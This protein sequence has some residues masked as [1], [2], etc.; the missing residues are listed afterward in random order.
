MGAAS[1]R[2]GGSCL[3]LR[4]PT[5]DAADSLAPMGAC[6][7]AL[8]S[9]A[10]PNVDDVHWLAVRA[11]RAR[12]AGYTRSA[13]AAVEAVRAAL[14][15]LEAAGAPGV[16][17]IDQPGDVIMSDCLPIWRL[18][19]HD[20]KELLQG[21]ERAEKAAQ[22]LRRVVALA[23]HS[24]RRS[25]EAGHAAATRS[26]PSAPDSEVLDSIVEWSKKVDCDSTVVRIGKRQFDLTTHS[27]D[28]RF[29]LPATGAALHGWTLAGRVVFVAEASV[30]LCT[31]APSGGLSCVDPEAGSESSSGPARRLFATRDDH[32]DV[33]RA[34]LARARR[35]ALDSF[36]TLDRTRGNQSRVLVAVDF[37][38]KQWE[39]TDAEVFDP[40]ER[41]TRETEAKF[42]LM[43]YGAWQG[44]NE[45]KRHVYRIVNTTHAEV[46]AQASA[47]LLRE[48]A[49][50]AMVNDPDPAW[51]VDI[52]AFSFRTVTFPDVSSFSW[53]G[54]AQV[55]GAFVWVPGTYRGSARVTIHEN[56]HNLGLSHAGFLDNGYGNNNDNM[57]CCKSGHWF[58]Q[59]KMAINW[60]PRGL[61]AE[62][63]PAGPTPACPHCTRGGSFILFPHDLGVLPPSFQ[64]YAE[65]GALPSPPA[66][67]EAGANFSEISGPGTVITAIAVASNPAS[68]AGKNEVHQIWLDAKAEE[69]E[70]GAGQLLMAVGRLNGNNAQQSGYQPT[71]S[72]TDWSQSSLFRG[73]SAVAYGERLSD[74]GGSQPLSADRLL[75]A[76]ATG[77]RPAMLV[78]SLAEHDAPAAGLL[79]PG[80]A[81]SS[82]NGTVALE[83]EPQPR[84]VPSNFDVIP[85]GIRPA[86]VEDRCWVGLNA[87]S[88]AGAPTLDDPACS[89][90]A[91]PTRVSFLGPRGERATLGAG[92][93]LG[94]STCDRPATSPHGT[95]HMPPLQSSGGA[96]APPSAAIAALAASSD[97]MS[98]VGTVTA[99]D[100]DAAVNGSTPMR[101]LYAPLQAELNGTILLLACGGLSPSAPAGTSPPASASLFA[102]AYS[103]DSPV[104]E[105]VAYGGRPTSALGPIGWARGDDASLGTAAGAAGVSVESLREACGPDHPAAAA[106]VVS[107][108]E[109][110]AVTRADYLRAHAAY[111]TS[112]AAIGTTFDLSPH[113]LAGSALPSVHLVAGALRN[114]SETSA[115]HAAAHGMVDAASGTGAA[116]RRAA[117]GQGLLRV[118]LHVF[119]LDVKPVE[120]VEFLG[121]VVLKGTWHLDR[122]SGMYKDRFVWERESN[123][124]HKLYWTGTKWFSSTVLGSS[125]RF[126]SILPSPDT[127]T[128]SGMNGVDGIS[129]TPSCSPGVY[130]ASA[131]QG[132]GLVPFGGRC[133]ACPT[134]L[135][136]DGAG[137]CAC[138]AGR[139]P[140]ST[141]AMVGPCGLCPVGSYKAIV[142]NDECTVCP[143]SASTAGVGSVVAGACGQSSDA[144]FPLSLRL[145]VGVPSAAAGGGSAVVQPPVTATALP[146]GGAGALVDPVAAVT[147]SG[148]HG[149]CRVMYGSGFVYS[150]LNQW[151]N[152][153]PNLAHGARPVYTVPRYPSSNI[154]LRAATAG[155]TVREGGIWQ[156][157]R[158]TADFDDTTSWRVIAEPQGDGAGFAPYIHTI[159]PAFANGT[160]TRWMT[161][162]WWNTPS[163]VQH[164]GFRCVCNDADPFSNTSP[165]ELPCLDPATLPDRP[166][167]LD[168]V[169]YSPTCDTG[170][171]LSGGECVDVDECAAGIPPCGSLACTN[172][173]GSFRCQ[174]PVGTVALDIAEDV[175]AP[176]SAGTYSSEDGGCSVCPVGTTSAPGS[177][178][179]A[180]CTCL[181]GTYRA[182]GAPDGSPCVAPDTSVLRTG[183]AGGA[184]STAVMVSAPA[185][186]PAYGKSLSSALGVEG[187]S[188]D[189]TATLGAT[190]LGSAAHAA[191]TGAG[192]RPFMWGHVSSSTEAAAE[193]A[194]LPSADGDGNVAPWWVGR[195]AASLSGFAMDPADV[196][197]NALARAAGLVGAASGGL[198]MSNAV[199]VVSADDVDGPAG[200]SNRLPPGLGQLADLD[201]FVVFGTG[202]TTAGAGV[203]G[204]TVTILPPSRAARRGDELVLAQ[205]VNDRAIQ[206]AAG[207]SADLHAMLVPSLPSLPNA[208]SG[209]ALSGAFASASAPPLVFARPA[210]SW[211]QPFDGAVLAVGSTPQD[212]GWRSAVVTAQTS[213]AQS[214]SSSPES[215]HPVAV[216]PTSL[217]GGSARVYRS[218]RKDFVLAPR[219][220][221]SAG[222]S[223]AASEDAASIA[224]HVG[225]PRTAADDATSVRDAF[226]GPSCVMLAGPGGLAA[227]AC[228]AGSF[229]AMGCDAVIDSSASVPGSL[230]V[231]SPVPAGACA[232]CSVC[233]AGQ[234]E[235]AACSG[236][237]DTV[238]AA[239]DSAALPASASGKCSDAGEAACGAGSPCGRCAAGGWCGSTEDCA[240]GLACRAAGSAAVNASAVAAGAPPGRTGLCLPLAANTTSDAVVSASSPEQL[241]IGGHGSVALPPL[242]EG[243]LVAVAVAGSALTPAD[244]A[245]PSHRGAVEQALRWSV[246]A[247]TASRADAS[248]QLIAA[249]SA[250]S[251]TAVERRMAHLSLAIGANASAPAA[252]SNASAGMVA[253]NPAAAGTAAAINATDAF[254]VVPASGSD[255]AWPVVSG[256]SVVAAAANAG[257]S[258]SVVVLV[259]RVLP[260]APAAGATSFFRP[261]TPGRGSAAQP[262]ATSETRVLS[263]DAAVV[264][265]REAAIAAAAD[266][267]PVSGL[268]AL[269]RSLGVEAVIVTS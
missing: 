45:H 10:S 155:A 235:V 70:T 96:P 217:G 157:I 113:G 232:A 251:A 156:V 215:W 148:R 64:S 175:C 111:G 204:R 88:T 76:V 227:A 254:S 66:G 186:L 78:E 57:G 266:P 216:M 115:W 179:I 112:A 105:V 165:D 121:G 127:G 26:G 44:I 207:G 234:V 222:A 61:L 257:P 239:G 136:G 218:D 144:S 211:R 11:R 100:V 79:P 177:A 195:P 260:V 81:A 91:R 188:G 240:A 3:E 153:V 139:S 71:S 140:G 201:A 14:R 82:L 262:L 193:S 126:D 68:E 101:R 1:A 80:M 93:E 109:H 97:S 8:A 35:L 83:A 166:S 42:D 27:N 162:E 249:V 37:A 214:L 159:L 28:E 154:W 267:S 90:I 164:A 265:V 180:N 50:W 72:R 182:A 74:I 233:G 198:G 51:R 184:V 18:V 31:A 39:L 149:W 228:G 152:R 99:D 252:R 229:L 259:L 256:K 192:P 253:H 130:N 87:S 161:R 168:D 145:D 167:E 17:R 205:A 58:T 16:T 212:D 128:I 169:T 69:A 123:P 59:R 230:A 191:L 247:R 137:S 199:S 141:I 43:S 92:C 56:G 263:F 62:V 225:W 209:A 60:M 190:A 108:A 196:G 135:V 220:A 73:D 248:V 246:K 170:Y 231:R 75:D 133:S 46:T 54:L 194:C 242:S 12:E 33:S 102:A 104:H 206:R 38:D 142:S 20:R 172:T 118:A 55:G 226:A 245:D 197:L 89:S 250:T 264:A 6:A 185:F 22:E 4:S 210:A 98:Y 171:K 116:L 202:N 203:C 30:A 7:D 84:M 163:Y 95:I 160:E 200:A 268:H 258:G 223:H 53:G 269:A 47:T 107:V 213:A 124:T 132:A 25:L 103:G 77:T 219:S 147:A 15:S 129:V 143:S 174:C 176:C 173:P 151:L 19:E 49:D 189:H 114:T 48:S 21:G 255:R 67:N 150:R 243:T 241:R 236:L 178:S 5:L 24:A 52:D 63:A 13:D 134:G 94:S 187:V 36:T 65:R 224:N 86:L 34:S 131:L 85:A 158:A 238:C 117:A 181:A 40:Y 119:Q 32:A 106:A 23:G 183:P 29:A 110:S 244:F 208:S 2:A 41:C 138:P 146:E 261:A 120:T 125:S 9:A 237:A 221:G 122:A